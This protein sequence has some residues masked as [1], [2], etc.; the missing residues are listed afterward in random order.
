MKAL[1]GPFLLLCS[2]AQAGVYKWVDEAGN[3]HYSDSPPLESQSRGV[4]ELSKQGAVNKPAETAA[5]RQAREASAAAARQQQQ[6]RMDA[7]RHDQALVQSYPTLAELQAD[8][9]R[10]LAVLQ[11]SY[12]ALELRS[13]GLALQRGHLEQDLEHAR[14]F[15]QTPPAAAVRNLQ[16]L[17]QSQQDLL[18]QM[19]S[20]RAE[21]DAFRQRMQ[22]DIARYRQLNP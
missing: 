11:S 9:E 18:R 17:R 15:K 1:A 5:Q 4:A 19:A 14:Q 21:L 6:Q 12:H 20:K 22:Q 7:A 10:Q 16:L 2:L 8:R 3:T 13:Q